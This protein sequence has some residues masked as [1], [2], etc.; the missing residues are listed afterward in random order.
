MSANEFTTGRRNG[1]R[2]SDAAPLNRAL[3]PLYPCELH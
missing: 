2:A 3:D 1:A